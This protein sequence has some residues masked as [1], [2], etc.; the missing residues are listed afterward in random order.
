MLHD[1][2]CNIYIIVN[3]LLQFYS[4]N[5]GTFKQ[6]VFDVEMS[7]QEA[8]KPLLCFG[9]VDLPDFCYCDNWRT[10]E[11]ILTSKKG[12]VLMSMKR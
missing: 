1:R 11:T 5:E 6:Y 3:T 7:V 10:I 4:E 12:Q 2:A 9:I 8:K